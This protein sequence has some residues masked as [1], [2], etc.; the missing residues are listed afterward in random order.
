MGRILRIGVDTVTNYSFE[1]TSAYNASAPA[2]TTSP[3]SDSAAMDQAFD[4]SSPSE[5]TAQGCLVTFERTPHAFEGSMIKIHPTY[6]SDG[7]ENPFFELWTHDSVTLDWTRRRRLQLSNLFVGVAS[8]ARKV[9]D[10]TFFP[11]LLHVDKVWITMDPGTVGAPTMRFLAI[12][13]FGQCEGTLVTPNPPG[14][15]DA[16]P[17]ISNPNGLDADGNPCLTPGVNCSDF[18]EFCTEPPFLDLCNPASVAAYEE[19]LR[20]IP[21]ALD[22]FRSWFATNFVTIASWCAGNSPGPSPPF[23]N[24]PSPPLPPLP[25]LHL[26]DPDSV[27]AFRAALSGDQESL[28]SFD[29]FVDALDLDGF[30]ARECPPP[31]P[32][33]EYVDPTT[34]EPAEEPPT[35]NNTPFGSGPGGMPVDQ[36]G[37][38]PTEAGG[39]RVTFES[40]WPTFIF[41]SAAR[42]ANYESSVLPTEPQEIQDAYV[43]EHV[44][45]PTPWNAPSTRQQGPAEI[46]VEV[47]GAPPGAEVGF[48]LRSRFVGGKFD[49]GAGGLPTELMLK[50]D[51]DGTQPPDGTMFPGTGAGDADTIAH[52]TPEEF[53]SILLGSIEDYY[54]VTRTGVGNNTFIFTPGTARQDH[55]F[56][57]SSGAFAGTGRAIRD[58]LASTVVSISGSFG[59]GNTDVAQ[60]AGWSFFLEVF[61]RSHAVFSGED[62]DV[63]VTVVPANV[64]CVTDTMATYALVPGMATTNEIFVDPPDF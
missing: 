6:D 63:D 2:A 45:F 34:L 64:D 21:G 51:E 24:P 38:P 62:I 58:K 12:Q 15:G 20:L 39:G 48:R 50:L 59:S 47:Q 19:Y 30:F 1:E 54:T 22:A 7:G 40:Y 13:L 23:P 28:D 46:R 31:D 36:P 27:E 53:D 18:P 42:K 37:N 49:E 10:F 55:T 56:A 14:D 41:P 25:P 17:C 33:E 61:L 9:I 35:D 5:V 11:F 52:S 57:F 60:V 16:D 44:Q 43:A 4:Q 29:A 26:C 3:W 32:A 8:G